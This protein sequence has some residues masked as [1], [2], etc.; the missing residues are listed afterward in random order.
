[1]SIVCICSSLP[2]ERWLLALFDAFPVAV[3]RPLHRL[4]P[5]Q[6]HSRRWIAVRFDHV[7][8]FVVGASVRV[9]DRLPSVVY[10][11]PVEMVYVPNDGQTAV[12]PTVLLVHVRM[13]NL[14]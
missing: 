9:V 10:G 11:R 14:C 12:I 3:V 8:R 13:L 4:V 7:R 5:F 6:Y 1:M 2:D